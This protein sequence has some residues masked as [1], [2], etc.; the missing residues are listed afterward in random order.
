ML[1]YSYRSETSSTKSK[2]LQLHTHQPQPHT[3]KLKTQVLFCK[4]MGFSALNKLAVYV[5]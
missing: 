1:Q 2:G 4:A 3:P 5:F